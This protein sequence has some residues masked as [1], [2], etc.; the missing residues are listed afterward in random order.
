MTTTRAYEPS[1]STFTARE[2]AG[3]LCDWCDRLA[4]AIVTEQITDGRT[5][6]DRACRQCLTNNYPGLI[7]GRPTTRD[8]IHTM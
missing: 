2:A 5:F 3:W 7:M 1:D 6:V 8:R 4:V